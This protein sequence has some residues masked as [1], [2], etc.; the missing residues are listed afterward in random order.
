M[1][2]MTRSVCCVSLFLK[3]TIYP[4]SNIVKMIDRKNNVNLTIRIKL[5]YILTCMSTPLNSTCELRYLFSELR[6]HFQLFLLQN[7]DEELN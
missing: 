7:S 5:T 6:Y 3:Y 4:L 2:T 1:L